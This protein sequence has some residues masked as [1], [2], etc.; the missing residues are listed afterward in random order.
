M[1]PT[2]FSFELSTIVIS[3]LWSLDFW[4]RKHRLFCGRSQSSRCRREDKAWP[5]PPMINDNNQGQ[6]WELL[7][8]RISSPFLLCC[9]RDFLT[10]RG[11]QMLAVSLRSFSDEHIGFHQVCLVSITLALPFLAAGVMPAAVPSPDS[12]VLLEVQGFLPHTVWTGCSLC[13]L[14]SVWSLSVAHL[15]S[16][17]NIT[18]EWERKEQE[19]SH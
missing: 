6:P 9:W 12:S 7:I 1:F 13:W 8:P 4:N 18:A 10:V 2:V 15:G 5:V 16:A 17:A 3:G 14:L 19:L 11:W